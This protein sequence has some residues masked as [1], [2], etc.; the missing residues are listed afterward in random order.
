MEG[1]ARFS[2][3]VCSVCCSCN[4]CFRKPH[5]CEKATL[6]RKTTCP[7]CMDT[8][9]FSTSS[10][11]AMPCG[12]WIHSKCALLLGIRMNMD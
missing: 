2:S 8:L 5:K 10:A 3:G 6:D 1:A 12:H 11:Q 7:I 4:L 9:F